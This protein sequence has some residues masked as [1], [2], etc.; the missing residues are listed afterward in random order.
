MT[1]R[2]KCHK[3]YTWQSIKSAIKLTR[4]HQSKCG[5]IDTWPGHPSK[6]G[7][8]DTK[9][10]QITPNLICLIFGQ[11]KCSSR[12]D[13]IF[14]VVFRIIFKVSFYQSAN[15]YTS[16]NKYQLIYEIVHRIVCLSNNCKRVLN[17]GY[18]EPVLVKTPYINCFIRCFTF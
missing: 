18:H 6:C 8:S 3:M 2:Q 12:I 15:L 5:K 16:M 9:A 4:G 10:R 1:T 13:L 11:R 17:L 7:K 14:F